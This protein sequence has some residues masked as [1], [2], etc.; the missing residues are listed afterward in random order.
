MRVVIVYESLFGNT[1]RIAEAIAQGMREAAPDAQVSCVRATEANRDVALGADLLVVGGP[2]HLCGLSS[3]VSRRMELKAEQ[4]AAAR[5]A[6]HPVEPDAAG[7]GL[8]DWF[9]ALPKA[10]GG[11]LGAAFDT[12]TDPW[13]T[14]TAAD[15]IARLLRRHGYE[16]VAE[17]Q[18][19]VIEKTE[20]PLRGGEQDRARAWGA[21]LLRQP[22]R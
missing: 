13:E 21:T 6:G 17:P 8:R 15:S 22:V 18:G 5:E 9:I 10:A 20:G 12:H 7:P 11:S 1:R 14:A 19:F 3:G 2:T 4:V 16:L